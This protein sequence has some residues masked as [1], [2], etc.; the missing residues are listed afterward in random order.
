MNGFLFALTRLHAF[1]VMACVLLAGCSASTSSGVNDSSAPAVKPG[2]TSSVLQ[3]VRAAGQIGNELDV[4]PLRD[5]QVEDLRAAATQMEN[6]GDYSGAQRLLAQAMLLS[7]EDPDLLQW[8]AELALVG[9]DYGRAEELANRSYARGPKLG[10]L[11]RRNFMTIKLASEARGN[12]AA[13]A[14]AQ[15]KG[16]ACTVAPPTR[17]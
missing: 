6:R 10:G 2:S 12:V 17:M 9:R 14:Q 11:C 7:P 5:P 13:A 4:Q 16:N 1:A 8:Q 15:A 3:Q